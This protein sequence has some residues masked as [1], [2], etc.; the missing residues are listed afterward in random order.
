MLEI[1]DL[2]GEGTKK[3]PRASK[4]LSLEAVPG[5]GL[6]LPSLWVIRLHCRGGDCGE[7]NWRSSQDHPRIERQV[8]GAARTTVRLNSMEKYFWKYFKGEN[9]LL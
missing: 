5:S 6:S 2:L 8:S 4:R 3:K 1:S 7:G 9:K